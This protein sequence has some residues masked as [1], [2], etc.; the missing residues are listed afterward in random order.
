MLKGEPE[1][2]LHFCLNTD[3]AARLADRDIFHDA[4]DLTAIPVAHP[5]QFGR[6][7]NALFPQ[8]S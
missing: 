6:R 7:K 1:W 8:S 2:I 5:A 3:V 4:R